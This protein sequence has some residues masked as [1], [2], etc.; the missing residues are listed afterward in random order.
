[1]SLKRNCGVQED[2]ER[3]KGNYVNTIHLYA[4]K[5]TIKC[6]YVRKDSLN[7]GKTRFHI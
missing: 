5:N 7:A 1:M 4:I 6:K 3:E 2:L